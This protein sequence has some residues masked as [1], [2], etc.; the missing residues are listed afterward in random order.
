MSSVRSNGL[1][2]CGQ[3]KEMVI[4]RSGVSVNRVGHCG[5]QLRSV[6]LYYNS[7]VAQVKSNLNYVYVNSLSTSHPYKLVFKDKF[8]HVYIKWCPH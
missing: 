6:V 2:I 8:Y 5:G 3:V 4:Y 7:C 1:Q